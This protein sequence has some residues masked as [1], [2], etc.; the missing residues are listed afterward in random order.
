MS[1]GLSKVN[2]TLVALGLAFLLLSIFASANLDSVTLNSPSDNENISGNYLLTATV[3]QWALNVSFYYSSDGST[4]NFIATVTNTTP[5]QSEF[6][7]LWDTTQISDGTY[8]F[9][10]TATNG[11]VVL[12]DSNSNVGVDNTPPIITINSPQNNSFVIQSATL[13]V[14]LTEAHPHASWWELDANG[15]NFTGCVGC[16]EFEN[17]TGSLEDGEHNITVWANDTLGNENSTTVFFRA[18]STKVTIHVKDYESGV[19]VGGA[20]VN[21][22]N[23][24]ITF[25]N[26]TDA[27]GNATFFVDSTLLYNISVY[28][29]G[30]SSN[31]SL[32]NQNFTSSTD[33][34]VLLQGNS[35]LEGYVKEVGEDTPLPATVSVYDNSTDVLKY[36]TQ[37]NSTTGYYSLRIPGDFSYYINFS[38]TNYTSQ[39]KGNYTGSNVV[40]ASLY[41]EG[42]G[43]LTFIVRDKWNERPISGANVTV[44]WSVNKSK[45]TNSSGIAIVELP[46]GGSF[47]VYVKATGYMENSSL[48]GL[49][50]SEGVNTNVNVKMFGNNK[51]YGY[52]RDYENSQ[53]IVAYVELWN[54]DNTEKLGWSGYYYNTTSNS[55]GY[56]EIFYPS[57][58]SQSYIYIHC[59]SSGYEAQE[60]QTISGTV[61]RDVNLI[62]TETVKGKVV[63]KGNSSVGISNAT[64]SLL[65]ATTGVTIY[66]KI[67]DSRGNF[68]MRVRNGTNYTLRVVKSGYVTYID[69]TPYAT[70]HDY[71]LI[72]MEGTAEV[73]GKVVDYQNQSINIQGVE[74]KFTSQNLTYTTTTNANGEFKLN[75]SSGHTYNIL[76]TKAGYTQKNIAYYISGYKDLGTITLTGTLTVNGTVKTPGRYYI[77]SLAEELENVHITLREAGGSRVYSTTTD[78]HGIYTLYVPSD[79]TSYT[80]TFT[81]D[82]FKEKTTTHDGDVILT[83]ATHIEGRIYDKYSNENIPDAYIYVIEDKCL[84]G[85]N[86]YYYNATSNATGYYSIDVGL[87]TNYVI[88]AY[89]D[90]YQ[91]KLL[92]FTPTEGFPYDAGDTG[93]WDRVENIDLLGYARIYIKTVDDFSGD[94]VENSHVCFKESGEEECRYSEITNESGEVE[95]YV[96][97]PETYNIIINSLGY[98]SKDLGSYY[99]TSDFSTVVSL[100]AYATIHVY[101]QYAEEGMKDIPNANVS[102]Y[103]YN[104]VTNFQYT[105]NET[106]V[107]ITV[108]C[109]FV[110]RDGINVTLNGITKTTSGSS[111]LTFSHVPTGFHIV[112]IN[113]TLAGCGLD[114]ESISIPEGGKNYSFPDYS[115]YN[116][117][118]TNLIVKVENYAGSGIENCIVTANSS[119]RSYTANESGSGI[120]NFTYIVAD[121]YTVYANCTN[122]YL[123]ST[124][125]TAVPGENNNYTSS[126]LILKSYPGNLSIYVQN[127]TSPLSGVTVTLNNGTTLTSTATNGWANFT[128]L[129][130]VYDIKVNGTELGYEFNLTESYFVS[131]NQTTV[132]SY[133]L[134]QTVITIIVKNQTYGEVNGS[135][136]TLWNGS[137]IA[138]S[139]TGEPLTALTNSSGMAEFTRVRGARYNLT[140]TK[141]GYKE[142]N[143]TIDLNFRYS[144]SW[145][146]TYYLNK[147]VLEVT[148]KEDNAPL[149]N[150]LVR[151]R[152]SS[153][154]YDESGYTDSNG[155]VTFELPVG[156]VYNLTVEGGSRGYNYTTQLITIE[157]KTLTAQ[158]VVLGK[159][160]LNVTVKDT[161]GNFVE[162][163]VKVILSSIMNT[164]SSGNA[165]LYKV[166][167]ETHVLTVNGTLKGYGINSTSVTLTYGE[168]NFVS[169][170]GITR[171]TIHVENS[172]GAMENVTVTM[173]NGSSYL[174]EY[175]G[176][177]MLLNGSTDSNGNVTF[178]YVPTGRYKI[179]IQKNSVRNYTFY[180][181]NNSNSGKNNSLT[182]YLTLPSTESLDQGSES[183]T[184]LTFTVVNTTGSPIENVKVKVVNRTDNSTVAGG[185]TNSSGSVILYV[186]NDNTYRFVIDGEKVG[187]GKIIN[188][189]VPIG[190]SD[191]SEGA[192][193]ASGIVKLAINGRVNYKVRVTN[194]YGYYSY[195]D[196]DTG[197]VRNGTYDDAL[198]GNPYVRPSIQIPLTG[199]TNLTGVIY[200]GNFVNPVDLNYEPVYSKVELYSDEGCSGSVRYSLFTESNGSY[201]LYLSPKQL[202]SNVT[203]RY[204]M[205]VTAEGYTTGYEHN[206]QF[207]EGAIEINKSLEGAGKVQGTVREAVTNTP[208]SNV[209]VTLSSKTCY[210]GCSNCKA[211]QTLTGANGAFAL[212][213][214]SRNEYYPYDIYLNKTNYISLN[215][216]DTVYPGNTTL[217]YFMIP[218][219]M[220]IINVNV[221]GS[222]LTDNV[223]IKWGDEVYSSSS[224]Y[225]SL[226]NNVLSCLLHSG[227]R[228]LTVNGS[229]IGYGIYAEEIYLGQGSN[230]SR[231]IKLNQTNVTVWIFN[232]NGNPIDNITVSLGEFQNTTKNGYVFFNKVPG[233]YHNLIFSGT[234]SRIYDTGSQ[235]EEIYV[236]PGENNT[237]QYTFN[238]TQFLVEV[239]N[240][241][242]GL[243]GIKVYL[244]NENNTFQN[245]TNSSG[246]VLFREVPYGNYTVSFNYSQ[247]CL[248][249]YENKTENV[250]AELG[251]GPES[252]N[253]VTITLEDVEVRFNITNS[254]QPLENINVSLLVNSEIANNGY[255][256]KLTGLTDSNGTV[257]FHNVI[258]SD[259]YQTYTYRIDGNESGYGIFT[260]TLHLSQSTNV[261]KILLPLSL[262]VTI[263][264]QNSNPLEANVTL[265]L[266]SQIAQNT[267]GESLTANSTGGNAYFTYLYAGSYLVTATKENYTTYSQ[268]HS[269]SYGLNNLSITLTPS[270]TPTTST[271]TTTVGG[272]SGGG[273]G[274]SAGTFGASVKVEEEESEISGI[275][276]SKGRSTSFDLDEWVIYKLVLHSNQTIREGKIVLSKIEPYQLWE[277]PELSNTDW[278]IYKYIKIDTE[279]I[280]GKLNSVVIYFSVSKE[281]M[282]ENSVSTISLWRYENGW[283]KL[284]TEMVGETSDR[285]NYKATFGGFSYFAIA[286]Y[287]GLTSTVPTTSTTTTTVEEEVCGNGIC[288]PGETKETCPIDCKEFET[289]VD[290]PSLVLLVL[291]VIVGIATVYFYFKERVG[292]K[293]R[294][295]KRLPPPP[296][297]APITKVKDILSE[298]NRYLNKE[299]MIEGE[300]SGSEFLP[301]ENRVSYRI[302]DST[303][304]IEGRSIRA[305]YEGKGIIKGIVKKKRGKV[306]VEF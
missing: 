141:S 303:G 213:V 156:G 254:T 249:G 265:Y 162:D 25:S 54:E 121:T 174:P 240:E 128:D 61:Q 104:N 90:G 202:G 29:T 281:W 169:I 292:K 83:G 209:S 59:N 243:G 201:K 72:E 69:T 178:S 143:T 58:L 76:F 150:I 227:T 99:I 12:S 244:E 212:N 2:L 152:N 56:Y 151:L 4:W 267:K 226:E 47:N 269:F 102:L 231:S 268:V 33:R 135:N 79:I 186:P 132:L 87:D 206:I 17:N 173:L 28:R 165:I 277:V 290:V 183:D 32:T 283:R 41:Q 19:G 299:V 220:G 124:N 260:Q 222:N 163:G 245:V 298:P 68:S 255:G 6:T 148:V 149:S 93:A 49:T 232:Q 164:T 3:S 22:S 88:Y 20:E 288:E 14:S 116:L 167:T 208:L 252:G 262:N 118:P 46:A 203:V 196:N 237:Y 18:A 67:T 16:T 192:T 81:R 297:P 98:P 198:S 158:E 44:E 57:T 235:T 115:T 300:V 207:Q 38:N 154:G 256:E 106:T 65:N 159:N 170:L 39:V 43:S 266:N 291:I 257:T 8:Y 147:T 171:L 86:C 53:P 238:E 261:T 146:H 85:S 230:I 304:E 172:S 176:K 107:N 251:K 64:V 101:D 48:K 94:P 187:Y 66:E 273:G 166:P 301:E 233:G 259:C 199:K 30:Y 271:T 21:L 223:T 185:Y 77:D 120:Y 75:V 51:I 123:N 182:L 236:A 136:V 55:S 270:S 282:S 276:L 139:A 216:N 157:N 179:V 109:N 126:P 108:T 70:S 10:A 190:E 36:Q 119:S 225:C 224:Q 122:Y 293:K 241:S 204:C 302:K 91:Y 287:G 305:G 189:S 215:Y 131:P 200:D 205:R 125:Y 23:P 153:L 217:S 60:I 284:D 95:F 181:I 31:T 37:T 219:G 258:P 103:Y 52:I 92:S 42:Y 175:N 278:K 100:G 197:V 211:Y 50:V 168:N 84:Q 161:N 138:T 112:E 15:T 285:V 142:I 63:D 34:I 193:S 160:S 114:T 133:I 45:L 214:S 27:N 137:E 279:N 306:Y 145:I 155:N 40:N 188:Y 7:Y 247:L 272:G 82:G 96:K 110:Q 74:I 71:G 275:T 140:I 177:E 218:L 246:F 286:G 242:S 280:E 117:H 80:L 184:Q 274:G 105:L 35:T 73:T 194:A 239:V 62:G 130:G 111:T 289:E 229:E 127:S 26:T 11:S 24:L 113:G 195:D 97:S 5:Q 210:G 253:N 296:P 248:L 250:E 228:T 264:D 134:N 9:N 180:E 294:E 234:V 295:I 89:A 221:T 1:T 191:V 144:S 129:S 13:N 78:Y 263:K